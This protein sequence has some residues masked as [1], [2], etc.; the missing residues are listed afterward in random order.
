MKTESRIAGRARW[1]RLALTGHML[2]LSGA[3]LLVIAILAFRLDAEGEHVFLLIVGCVMLAGAALAWRFGTWAKIV[4]IV[5]AVLPAFALFWTAFGIEAFPSFFDFMPAL[6]VI[7]GAVLAVVGYIAS[8]VAGRRGHRTSRATEGERTAIRAALAV[9]AVVALVTGALTIAGR[10][11]VDASRADVAI[12]ASDFEFRAERLSVARGSTILV[13]NSDP[14][15]HTFTIDAL[16]ID[17]TLTP[18]ES[19]LVKIPDEAGSY[20]F[21]CRPHTE[22][23][24]NPGE[25]DMAGRMKVV[26]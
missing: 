3:L 25:D 12:S 23:P 7:P 17:E 26:A 14:F 22:D 1:A 10:S 19:V 24:R 4:G 9:V 21:Y 16:R 6:L 8:I 13:K 2:E 5:A 15:L 20:I 18:G 11:S